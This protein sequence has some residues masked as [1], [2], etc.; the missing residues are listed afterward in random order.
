[1]QNTDAMLAFYRGLGLQVNEGAQAC[2]V[3]IGDQMINSIIT[4]DAARDLDL[5]KGDTAAALVKSTEVMI[6]RV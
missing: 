6:L 1:M 3:Y 2:S 4:A 5:K